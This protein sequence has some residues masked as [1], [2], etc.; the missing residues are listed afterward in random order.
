M[1]ERVDMVKKRENITNKTLLERQGKAI[2]L[3]TILSIALFLCANYV[4]AVPPITTTQ[5]FAEG[6]AI[7]LPQDNVL[8]Q[9]EEYI[10]D[11]HIFNI[12][13]GYPITKGI[14]CDFSL[15]GLNGRHLAVQTNS[16]PDVID[17][18]YSFNISKGNFSELKSLYYF[19]KCNSSIKGGFGE[20]ILRV[21]RTGEE[22]QSDLIVVLFIIAF[23]VIIGFSIYEMYM[24][25]THV[26]LIEYDV[27][28]FAKAGG[29]YFAILGLNLMHT[30]FLGNPDLSTWFTLFIQIGLWTNII[31]PAMAL[32]FTLMLGDWIKLNR[33]NKANG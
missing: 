31:I 4:S 14:S 21:T 33:L 26:F 10:F 8:K 30:N 29:I 3:L 7:Q 15:Y 1:G 23:V 19:I 11:F 22:I 18:C 6:Y 9:G 20:S 12:S 2:V 16:I 5:T 25:I 24:M 17:G 13:N 27:I 32:A 28:D